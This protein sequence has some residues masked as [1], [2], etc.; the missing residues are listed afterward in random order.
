MQCHTCMQAIGDHSTSA[1][2]QSNMS[3]N[4][5]ELT[6]KLK[7]K[8]NLKQA[9]WQTDNIIRVLIVT[10]NSAHQ[11]AHK[12]FIRLLFFTVSSSSFS[13]CCIVVT[14][15]PTVNMPT[16]LCL[17]PKSTLVVV[18]QIYAQIHFRVRIILIHC[19]Y[20]YIYI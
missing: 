18:A 4:E 3:F 7:L 16:A 8:E 6:L 14:E 11:L 13:S 19:R 9:V 12:F 2:I 5:L 10:D 17:V 15:Y 1:R 20:V